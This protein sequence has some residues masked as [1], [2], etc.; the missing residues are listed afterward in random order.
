MQTQFRLPEEYKDFVGSAENL[1]N[2]LRGT[3]RNSEISEAVEYF[4]FSDE[5]A[6]D[7]M[8]W[9]RM[10]IPKHLSFNH[11]TIA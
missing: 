1:F 9:Y 11:N 4:V 7:T 8:T 6:A 3:E 5:I 2:E 10:T